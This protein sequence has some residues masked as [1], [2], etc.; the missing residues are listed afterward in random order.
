MNQILH[1]MGRSCA[2]G[3][4]AAGGRRNIWNSNWIGMFYCAAVD[5]STGAPAGSIKHYP[6]DIDGTS[7]RSHFSRR[8]DPDDTLLHQFQTATVR[9]TPPRVRALQFAKRN[10][11]RVDR[12]PGSPESLGS[13][14]GIY[15]IVKTCFEKRSRSPDPSSK[16]IVRQIMTHSMGTKPNSNWNERGSVH[17]SLE[18]PG[19]IISSQIQIPL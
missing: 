3:N 4:R 11:R 18:S 1:Q 7:R 19:S 2:K 12:S 6:E 17:M 16:T 5:S 15:R 8:T 13:F 9:N 14:A 10:C